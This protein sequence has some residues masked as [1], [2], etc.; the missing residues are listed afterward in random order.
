MLKK[1]FKRLSQSLEND[2]S[3]LFFKKLQESVTLWE[4]NIKPW[5]G[6]L[7]FCTGMYE[8]DRCDSADDEKSFQRWLICQNK[9]FTKLL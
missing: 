8:D 9:L 3:G 6:V 2:C 1:N 4:Q 5:E 7:D